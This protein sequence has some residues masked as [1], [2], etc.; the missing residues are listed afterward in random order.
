[1][2]TEK[3]PKCGA[4]WPNA[5]AEAECR[6]YYDGW[7]RTYG[8]HYREIST[9]LKL[10]PDEDPVAVIKERIEDA[11]REGAEDMDRSWRDREVERDVE[12]MWARSEAKRGI[13]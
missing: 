12:W 11:Y 7:N 3:C 6:L 2:N 4:A 5:Q 1:M 13:Q 8:C 9:L 10:T